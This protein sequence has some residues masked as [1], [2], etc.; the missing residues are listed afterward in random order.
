[1]R[2][3][4]Y[5]FLFAIGFFACNPV[6]KE[7]KIAIKKPAVAPRRFVAFSPGSVARFGSY[8]DRLYRSTHYTGVTLLAF[9]DSMYVWSAGLADSALML[10]AE[11]PM[12]I[13]SISKTFCATSVMILYSKSKLKLTD[14]LRQYFPELPYYNIS[15][16]QML[17]HSTGL[18]EYTWFTDH[19][20]HDSLGQ[21][22]NARLIALMSEEKPENYFDPGKRH[23]YCNTNFVLLASI[24]EKVSGMPYPDFVKKHIL[25]PL[26]MQKTKVLPAHFP[27]KNLMVKGHYGDGRVF[28]EHYQ[29]GTYGDKNIVSTVGDLYLFY[30][31]LRAN[32]LFPEAIKNEMFRTRWPNARRGTGY[33]LG[34]R[35]RPTENETWMFHSGWWHGFRTN[36]YFSLQEDKCAITLCNRLSGGFIP[37]A[38]IIAM[39]ND[40]AWAKHTEK[41]GLKKP[42]VAEKE[43]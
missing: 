14:T 30:K 40:S 12:Q 17:S 11:M 39:F 16:E 9:K 13:A 27:I 34:W 24:V 19:M 31:G 28:P 26:G 32:K 38:T 25:D 35:V 33:A 22:D 21:I 6:V 4:F 7:S 43:E 18:P 3:S 37:G 41:W 10:T 15:L 29:D 2:Y 1:M 42:H 8:W 23:H 36:F 5:I 20:W